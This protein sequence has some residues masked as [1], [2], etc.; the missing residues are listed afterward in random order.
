MIWELRNLGKGPS[1][2]KGPEM[3][4]SGVGSGNRGDAS[5]GEVQK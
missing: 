1:E 4:T 5:V 2:G 3:G